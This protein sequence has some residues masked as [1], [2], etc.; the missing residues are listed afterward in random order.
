MYGNKAHE[1]ASIRNYA[2]AERHFNETKPV[3]S[4]TGD[5]GGQTSDPCVGAVST[6]ID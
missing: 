2:A 1:C 4:R 5:S 3:K 6:T